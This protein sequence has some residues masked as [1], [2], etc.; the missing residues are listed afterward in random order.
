ML[1]RGVLTDDKISNLKS[2]D[3]GNVE[4]KWDDFFSHNSYWK[5][6]WNLKTKNMRWVRLLSTY[7][8]IVGDRVYL[9][10][11]LCITY[12]PTYFLFVNAHSLGLMVEKPHRNIRTF[13]K[14]H[15]YFYHSALPGA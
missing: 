2:G 4:K 15:K 1:E 3:F 14:L 13:T 10:V 6:K 9:Y 11:G 7:Y 12:L 8:L 5:K